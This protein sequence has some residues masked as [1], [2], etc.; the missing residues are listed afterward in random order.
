VARPSIERC[1]LNV[2]KKVTAKM[3]GISGKF[4]GE[5]AVEGS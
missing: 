1:Q 3:A 5:S 4:G 2:N